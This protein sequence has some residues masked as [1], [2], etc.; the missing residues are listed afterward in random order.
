MFHGVVT[1]KKNNEVTW[2]V[3]KDFYNLKIQKSSMGSPDGVRT[4]NPNTTGCMIIHHL[5]SGHDRMP[6]QCSSALQNQTLWHVSKQLRPMK[7]ASSSSWHDTCIWSQG[8]EACFNFISQPFTSH[9]KRMTVQPW[10]LPPCREGDCSIRYKLWSCHKKAQQLLSQYSTAEIA[11]PFYTDLL[12]SETISAF[13]RP[14]SV[15]GRIPV[16]L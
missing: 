1:S 16:E 7:C 2:S 14:K 3:R 6:S 9:C 13:K 12:Y 10:A 15:R 8:T 5:H 11:I 4:R